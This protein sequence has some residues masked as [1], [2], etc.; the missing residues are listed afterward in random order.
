MELVSERLIENWIDNTSQ[1]LYDSHHNDTVSNIEV[2]R[3][4]KKH[5]WF[6]C[7]D[8]TQVSPSAFGLGIADSG[9]KDNELYEQ[10]EP[11]DTSIQK[12]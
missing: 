4:L 1:I 2:T 3:Y 7:Y 12:H 5:I 6:S 11:L 8:L 10:I 9:V